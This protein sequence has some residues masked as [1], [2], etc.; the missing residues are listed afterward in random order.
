MTKRGGTPL[1]LAGAAGEHRHRR[2]RGMPACETVIIGGGVAGLACAR[3]LHR[4]GREFRLITDRLGGRMYANGG[5]TRNFGATYLTRDY[6]HVGRFVDRGSR[7][8]RRDCYF[9]DGDGLTTL[10]HPRNVKLARALA[11]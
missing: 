3:R 9:P 4:A 8:R 10:F 1:A 11:R 7:I 2:A 6:R 5:A